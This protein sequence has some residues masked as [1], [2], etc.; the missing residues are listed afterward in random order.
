MRRDPLGLTILHEPT[1]PAIADLVFIH[2]L[3]GGSVRSWSDDESAESF[4]PLDW[5]PSE[6]LLEFARVHTY[7][8]SSTISAASLDRILDLSDHAKDL[9]DKLRFGSGREGHSLEIGCVPLIFIAHSLGG[10]IAKKAYLLALSDATSNYGQIAQ[11]TAAF[12]FFSTPHRE[13]NRSHVIDDILSTCVAGWRSNSYG[14]IPEKHLLKMQDTNEKFRDVA[15]YVKIYS[16]YERSSPRTSTPSKS[17]LLPQRSATLDHSSETQI[18]LDGDHTTVTKYSSKAEPN[19]LRVLGAL[20]TLVQGYQVLNSCKRS[21]MIEETTAQA[22]EVERLLRGCKAPTDDLSFFSDKRVDGSCAWTF[23]QPILESFLSD[24]GPVPLA[25]WFFGAPGSGK[26]V[27]ATYIIEQLMEESKI[28]AYYYFRSGDQLKNNLSQFLTSIASQISKQ[29]PE[30]RRKLFTLARDRFDVSKAGY[31]ILWKKLFVSTLFHSDPQKPLYILVDGLDEF[32]QSKELLERMFVD[33]EDSSIRVRLMMVSRPTLDIEMSIERL[34]KKIDIQKMSLDANGEGLEIY[35]R[36]EMGTMLGDDHFKERTLNEV[37]AKANGNFLWAHLVVQEILDCQ[38]EVQVENALR[39]VPK[40]LI[41]L[42]KRMDVQLA[43]KFRSRPQDKEM[44][45][46]IIMWATCAQRP[47]RLDELKGA[48]EHDFPRIIHMQRTVQR[49]CGEFVVV[50]KQGQISMMHASAREF[51]MSDSGLNYYINGPAVNRVLFTNCIQALSV[52]PRSLETLPESNLAFLKYAASS[53]PFH[54]SQRSDYR[55]QTSLAGLMKV[56]KSRIVLDWISMLARTGN[57][58]AMVEASKALTKLLTTA[59]RLGQDRSPLLPSLI[60]KEHLRAW[61]QDLI[62]VVGEFG[63]QITKQPNAVYDLL[64]AFCPKKS[65]MHRQFGLLNAAKHPKD[66]ARLVIKGRMSPYWD[67]CFAKFPIGGDASPHSVISLERYF[68]VLTR[69]DGIVHLY[70]STTCELARRLRHEEFV[71]TFCVDMTLSRVATYSLRR[72]IV[73]DVESG[74]LVFSIENPTRTK[75]LA[76]SFRRNARGDDNII[77]FSE[78]GI[79]R[80]CSLHAL[81]AEW[82]QHEAPADGAGHIHQVNAPHNAQ[83][84]HDGLYLAVSYRGT[85]PSVWYTGSERP[86]LVA[87]CDHRARRSVGHIH[88]ITNYQYAAAFAWNPLTGH[89]LGLYNDGLV[90]K[91]H[92]RDPEDFTS[93]D[94]LAMNIKCSA[95][96]KLFVTGSGDGTLRVW[97][98]DHFTPIYQLRYPVHIQDVELSRNE[99]RIYDLRDQYCNIWEPTS[100]LRAMGSD[101][102]A[103]GVR[104]SEESDQPS[105]VSE[106]VQEDFEPVTALE[107]CRMS[108]IYAFGD[109]AGRITVSSFDGQPL[110]NVEDGMMS[111]ERLIWSASGN[112]LASIDLGRKVEVRAF[113][114]SAGGQNFDSSR[115][116]LS[117]SE[118]S[119]ILQVLFDSSDTKL[120]MITPTSLKMQSINSIEHPRVIPLVH[121]STWAAHPQDEKMAIGLSSDH[122]HLVPWDEPAEM[123]TLP[124]DWNVEITLNR[125]TWQQLNSR[126]P[127]EAWLASPSEIDRHVRRIYTSP[128]GSLIMAEILDT[129]Q[130]R[131]RSDCLLI[132][133]ESLQKDGSVSS[134]PVRSIHPKLADALYQPLGFI[135]ADSL[136]FTGRGRPLVAQRRAMLRRKYG[137]STFVF[138]DKTFFVCSVDIGFLDGTNVEIHKHFFL[139]RDWQ[140]AEWLEMAT[141]TTSGNFLCP[142]NGDVAVVTNGFLDQFGTQW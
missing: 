2:S 22:E 115:V 110:W 12:I 51:L 13:L 135:D 96:G 6:H 134:V 118:Q 95:D 33:L 21:T 62:R 84:S 20:Q 80:S 4:W 86:R 87:N 15:S 58:C 72:T 103:N 97:D 52:G 79:V 53:W 55:D 3:G 111:I 35:L 133:T 77:T 91:W 42:Y 27:T 82:H 107:V 65:I 130:T 43:N 1:V 41:P 60:D 49:L 34:Q 81:R 106:S 78:D 9:L 46:L 38:T 47:L 142:R 88:G 114:S 113:K 31:K 127:S 121:V 122:I 18:P 17:L 99:A 5:L 109:D 128:D 54:L 112:L 45:H 132:R 75:A 50:D 8:Y 101:D 92:P 66:E 131:R 104:S 76:M 19:Y 11:A 70:Y 83:F 125:K 68:A 116:L 16:F 94:K 25:L 138:V 105:L 123:R 98:F 140:N 67:D 23:Y 40:E 126:R 48:L 139:P 44:G 108:P 120:M 61:S 136:N 59:D 124:Y 100:L 7:G 73:W 93:S 36:W 26:S 119:D 69:G 89:L 14:G 56:F 85:N 39:E 90:F 129:N 63:P 117:S 32:P 137:L 141:V 30:Y 64:P 37:L 28:C 29:V 71:T 24:S 102:I 57:L 74:K 10:L